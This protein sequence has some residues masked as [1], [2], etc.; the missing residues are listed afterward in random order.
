MQVTSEELYRIHNDGTTRHSG[1]T[2][3]TYQATETVVG[4]DRSPWVRLARSE[5]GTATPTVSRRRTAVAPVIGG[6]PVTRETR[7]EIE[8][9][10]SQNAFV[11]DV[12]DDIV[13]SLRERIESGL[14][15]VG[16]E[17]IAEMMVRRAV[18]D[19]LR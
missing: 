7:A 8:R 10:V 9:V 4:A 12:R 15:N 13:A 16:A 6:E 11:P 3:G 5:S 2:T 14:Y 19:Q 1:E 17:T 18:A